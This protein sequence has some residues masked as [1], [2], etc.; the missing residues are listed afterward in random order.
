[1]PYRAVLDNHK[2]LY[3]ALKPNM[4]NKIRLLATRYEVGGLS[5]NQKEALM[6]SVDMVKMGSICW[7]K[8]RRWK[9]EAGRRAVAVPKTEDQI[10]TKKDLPPSSPSLNRKNKFMC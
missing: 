1:M 6:K 9:S 10:K 7:E 2:L 4:R 8:P 5:C 3:K